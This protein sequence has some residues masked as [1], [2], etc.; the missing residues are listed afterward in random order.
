[1]TIAVF[2]AGLGMA[3][4]GYVL[5]VCFRWRDLMT[6]AFL[7]SVAFFL[8]RFDQMLTLSVLGRPLLGIHI[9]L[10]TVALLLALLRGVRGVTRR[11]GRGSA[12]RLLMVWCLLS[13]VSGAVHAGAEGL[14]AAAQ[15]LFIAVPPFVVAAQITD[16]YPRT[17]EANR[18]LR[19]SIALLIGLIT[20]LIMLLTALLPDVIGPA[21]G[22][23]QQ[24]VSADNGFVRGW[25]P[26]GSTIASGGL[27]IMAYGVLLHEYMTT[28]RP[29][30]AM[31]AALNV[32][33]I[34]FTLARSVLFAFLILHVLY[35]LLWARRQRL[36]QMLCVPVAIAAAVF[37]LAVLKGDYSFD[38]F[39]ETGDFSLSVRKASAAAALGVSIREPLLGA[40]PGLLY[41]EVRTTWLRSD[42]SGDK[43]RLMMVG[44]EMTAMEPHNMYLLIAAEHGWPA[45]LVFV[46]ILAV[47]IMVSL[48]AR[49]S[50][51]ISGQASLNIAIWVS[52]CLLMLTDSDPL[53]NAQFAVFFWLF[54]FLGVHAA[55]TVPARG[56]PERSREV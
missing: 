52:L 24:A 5:A 16:L 51:R 20:P 33:A 10:A 43:R 35:W 13:L 34:M 42:D 11:R 31:L 36:G 3:A 39:L 40:G 48:R 32:V 26:L 17:P 49:A 15:I 12:T 54:G 19:L 6:M 21:M 7:F 50:P 14:A 37:G 1:M 55:E 45:L 8:S 2:L 28:R 41:E 44:D 22:W 23:R 29:I 53:L 4:A 46:A 9:Y 18:R 56:G 38:R 47:P 27:V 25:S 30:F